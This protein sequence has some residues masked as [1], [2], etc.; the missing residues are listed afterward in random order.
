MIYIATNRVVNFLTF[1][2]GDP[3]YQSEIIT[4]NSEIFKKGGGDQKQY[5]MLKDM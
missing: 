5:E 2:K 4:R 1:S 3:D